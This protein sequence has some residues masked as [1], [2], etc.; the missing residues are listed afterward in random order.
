MPTAPPR[1][2]IESSSGATD[3]GTADLAPVVDRARA[4]ATLG[5][6]ANTRRCYASAWRSFREWTTDHQ[7]AALPA[8]SETVALYVADLSDRLRASS[9]R[10]HL[11]AIGS[12]HRSA[13]LVDPTKAESVRKVMRGIRRA[14]TAISTSKKPLRLRE[15]RLILDAMPDGLNAARD[16]ALLLLGFALGARRSELVALNVDDLETLPEGLRV[17]IARSKTDQEGEGRAVGVPYASRPDLC[18]VRAVTAWF[19]ASGIT[20]GAVFRRVDRWGTIGARLGDR[21][22]SIVVKDRAALAGLD[23]GPLGAHSLRAGLATE[24]A[25]AGASER[26]I[27]GQTGHRS[28]RVLRTYIHEGS[29]W[30]NNAAA[31]ALERRE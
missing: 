13:Q 28:L 5:T 15:L 26:A 21:S 17:F 6:A 7:L 16:R 23:P 1:C 20:D 2:T 3:V 4:L 8:T 24:A 30:R 27:M 9:L 22:V 10:L 12:A 11:A 29:L 18:P 25:A 19:D 31:A 14:Q